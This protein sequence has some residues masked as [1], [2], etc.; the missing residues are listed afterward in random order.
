MS[1]SRE[2][3]SRL[4]FARVLRFAALSISAQAEKIKK[5]LFDQGKGEIGVYLF[6][7]KQISVQYWCAF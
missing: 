4:L 7:F 2:H 1:T 6:V 5:N 3:A